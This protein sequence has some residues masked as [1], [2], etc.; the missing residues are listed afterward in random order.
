MQNNIIRNQAELG[1]QVNILQCTGKC[2]KSW[3]ICC[4]SLMEWKWKLSAR[5]LFFLNY[6]SI[7][8]ILGAIFT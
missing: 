2:S 3:K 6:E 5:D 7:T 1:S 4:V 8:G